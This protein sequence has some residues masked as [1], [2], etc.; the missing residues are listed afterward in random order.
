MT[1]NT[2]SR[3]SNIELLRILGILMIVMMHFCGQGG[4][5]VVHNPAVAF[6][7]SAGRLSVNI[8]LLIGCWFMVDAPF[9]PARIV[10]LYLQVVFYSIPIT[11]LMLAM[12]EDGGF[13]NLFQG[14]VPF[15]GRSVWFA[16]AYISLIALSPFLNKVFLLPLPALRKLVLLLFILFVVVSTIPNF[17]PI[18]YI[19]DFTWFCVVYIF[20]GWA[21]RDRFFER[22]GNKWLCLSFA[23]LM[24]GALCSLACWLPLGGLVGYWSAN[25]KSAP[26]FAIALF[27][28]AFFLKLDIGCRKW[29]NFAARSVFAVYVIHQIPAFMHYEW[30]TIFHADWLIRQSVVMQSV[31]IP[32][33]AV[34]VFAGAS[35]IDALRI[36]LEPHYLALRPVQWL[37]NWFSK[38]YPESECS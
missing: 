37:V 15:F 7:A 5:P 34:L 9:R 28:F 22:L 35:L 33:V 23:A 2:T 19:A 17:S 13:R 6:L 38:L 14:L 8:F 10:K 36:W 32:A 27:T 20:T 21:K 11:L 16:S 24:Y 18:D 26:A 25:I 1:A 30:H 12:G 4:F 29:I 31:G 3:A